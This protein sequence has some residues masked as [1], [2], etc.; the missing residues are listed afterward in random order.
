MKPLMPI[1]AT[2]LALCAAACAKSN[3]TGTIEFETRTDS[4]GYLVPDYYGDTVY[5]AARFSVVWPEKIAD[6][7]FDA[8]TDSLTAYTFG[9]TTTD[10]DKA[11]KEFLE[12][13]VND[14]TTDTDSASAPVKTS[15][16][17]ANDAMRHSVQ[18]VNSTVSLLTPTILV[19]DINNEWYDFG[20]AHGMSS[21]RVLNYSIAGHKLLTEQTMFKK[22]SEAKVLSLINEAARQ[23]YPEEGTLFPEPISFY[24]T[25][26]VT[27]NDIVFIY[28]PYDVAPFS[29]GIIEVPV[30]QYDL[31]STLTPE[32]M[33][34][35]GL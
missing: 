6:Q 26:K 32:A 1:C 11:A 29:S 30:T 21:L 27:E 28:Q 18:Y 19:I 34:A 5:A 9:S 13:S 24:S 8:L 12:S 3:D 33:E 15:F 35:L 14:L 2:L 23:R 22:G 4:I 25:F 16:T 20:S 17:E 31:Y 10:F 7:D